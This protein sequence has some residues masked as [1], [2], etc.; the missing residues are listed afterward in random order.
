MEYDRRRA[1]GRWAEWVGPAGL[2]GDRLTRRF[3]IEDSARLDWERAS[4]A[5]RAML[6]AFARGVNAFVACGGHCG[7]EFEIVGARPEPWRPWD[8]LAVFKIRHVDM[9]PWK[10]KLWRAR[11]VRHL[12]PERAAEL[13]RDTQPHPLLIVPPA[14][15]YRGVR[16]DALD[17]MERQAPLMAL[18]A[19]TPQGSNNWAL[20]GSRTASGKPLVAGDPHRAL[21]VPNVYY[22]NHLACPEWDAIGL[23]FPGVPGLPHFG[24]NRR[25]AWCVTHGMADY[26]DLYIERFDS[27]DPR[28]YEV[29][30]KWRQADV[31]LEIIAVRGS[32]PVEIETVLTHHG[33]VVI[34]E[35]R[36][37]HAIACAYTAI[38]GANSTIDAFIPMLQAQS[39]DQLEAAM[40][41]W[42]EPVNNLVFADVDGAIGYRARGQVPIRPMAH[43]WTP[44]PGWT[45]EHEWRGAIPFEETPALRDPDTGFVVTANS[46]IAGADYPHYLGL[47]YAPDFRTRRL[48]DRIDPLQKATAADMAAIHADRISLPA[49]DLIAVMARLPLR[50]AAGEHA[51]DQRWQAALASLLAWDRAMDGDEVAPAIY[52]ALRE[53]VIRALMTP[54]LGPLMSDAF[55]PVQNGGVVHMVK[56][57][58]RLGE[59]MRAGDRTLLPP[60]ADWATAIAR[61]LAAAVSD[62]RA[63][64]GDDMSQ[65]QWGRLHAARPQHPLVAGFPGLA[66][67]LNPPSV[68]L[69]GDGDTVSATGYVPGAGFQVALSSVARYVFDLSDWE[70]CGWIVPGGASGHPE[71]PHWADQQAAWAECRLVPMRYDW[72]GIA[73]CAESRQILTPAG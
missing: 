47:D 13:T 71:S 16:L 22:Q 38:R 61:A 33:P 35:P 29:A 17:A 73:A 32:A 10:A 58:A 9:G 30:G 27:S 7:V 1:Y 28:R 3:R 34:G 2:E 72:T 64:L 37:G 52:A 69:G 21:D 11:L 68:P 8:G 25:V 55:A 57:K 41:P 62:L 23:S 20:S 60:G 24:H 36:H 4:P 67:R 42:V 56:L 59:M 50:E 26:Q 65:W 70:A 44:V 5:A 49:R 39:A 46:K 14:A 54:I 48:V 45:G 18:V 12:G 31:R 19:G 51:N 66:A 15:E 40:R 63:V 6:D 53:R 43:A